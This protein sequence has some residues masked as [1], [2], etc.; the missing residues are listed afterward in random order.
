[1]DSIHTGIFYLEEL[2]Q[3]PTEHGILLVFL[4]CTLTKNAILPQCLALTVSRKATEVT[5]Q[6]LISDI[7][8][9]KYEIS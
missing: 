8:M 3:T 2:P 1:M 5:T 4:E 9:R 6:I 7:G